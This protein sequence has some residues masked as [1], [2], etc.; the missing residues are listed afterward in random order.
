MRTH[1]SDETLADLLDGAA[2]P[3]AAA[4]L[5]ACEPCRERLDEAR[6]G[7][8]LAR[9]ADVPEPSPLYWE[10]FPRQVGRRL[11]EGRRTWRRAVW[12]AVGALAAGLLFVALPDRPVREPPTGAA[13]LPA[14]SPLPAA[15]DDPGLEVLQAV[16]AE[17]ELEV[18]C[19]GLEECVSDLTDEEGGALAEMLR[20]EAPG[21]SS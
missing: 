17:L 3:A 13:R 8:A 16:A 5:G 12:P 21:R 4:H 14:W 19:E 9:R 18:E 11:A 20:R 2:D 7:M 10:A 1:V 15:D 6:I